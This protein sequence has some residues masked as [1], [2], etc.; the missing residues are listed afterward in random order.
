MID[1]DK[2]LTVLHRRFPGASQTQV[3]AATNAIVGLDDEWEDVTD[4]A[5]RGDGFSVERGGVR[6]LAP[7]AEVCA[8]FRLF[9][10]RHSGGY[11][12]GDCV[13]SGDGDNILKR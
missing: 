4:Q 11:S 13:K 3:A 10:R 9:R 12:S 8:E 1:R 2:V 5:S 7:D 6:Y